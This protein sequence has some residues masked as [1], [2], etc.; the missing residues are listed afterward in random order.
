MKDQIEDTPIN[1]VEG[2]ASEIDLG[3]LERD[4]LENELDL[5]HQCMIQTNPC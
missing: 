3:V 1:G 5:E 4:L 2:K